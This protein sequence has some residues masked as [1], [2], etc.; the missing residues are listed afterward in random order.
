MASQNYIHMKILKGILIA[1]IALIVLYLLVALVAPKTFNV[2]R[3]I[4]I[5]ATPDVVF[6]EISSFKNWEK[7]SPWIGKDSS[8]KN[9]Y[10]GPDRGVG[11]KSS[12]TSKKSG[13]GSMEIMDVVA[14]KYMKSKI[15]IGEGMVFESH[16]TLTPVAGGTEVTWADSGAFPFL[17]RPVGLMADKMMGP[18]LT[19][20][21]AN[22]KKY[23]ESAPPA[24]KLGEF[25]VEELPA[26]TVLAILDSCPA[27]ELG[28]KFGP[29]YGEIGVVMKKNKLDFAGP[30]M[31]YYYSYSPE[32]TV[33]EPAVPVGKEVKGEGRVKCRTTAKTRA[34]TVSFF[35]D[36]Q[37]L[38]KAWMA[39]NDYLK[40]NKLE[41]NGTPSEVYVTDPTTVK[42]KLQIETKINI[43]VK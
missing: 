1:I 20:G 14:A 2:E 23:L 40:T 12:W 38:S 31:A 8:I 15:T 32:K 42:D 21:L 4:T 11:N 13:N 16:L 27:S 19:D 29:M 18:D 7:W 43:P 17:G 25:K 36:Y 41:Q 5:N 34:V 24:Y 6:D 10:T 35:G 30:V 28:A 3:K 26:Q 37:Y 39:I 9:T 22:L 33:F